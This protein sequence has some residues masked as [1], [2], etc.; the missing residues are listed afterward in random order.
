MFVIF[1]FRFVLVIDD[2][3]IFCAKDFV[4]NCKFFLNNVT[5]CCCCFCFVSHNLGNNLI[6][7]YVDVILIVLLIRLYCFVFKDWDYH[8][9][10]FEWITRH[11]FSAKCT[12]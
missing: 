7:V 9:E 3:N 12:C 8:I 2:I 11:L 5:L 6:W 10:N 1:T 4:E